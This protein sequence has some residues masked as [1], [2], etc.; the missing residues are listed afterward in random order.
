LIVD[1]RNA[2]RSL[3]DSTLAEKIIRL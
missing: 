3:N 2:T 1:T